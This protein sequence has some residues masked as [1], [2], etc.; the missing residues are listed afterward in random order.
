MQ[1]FIP[2]IIAISVVT[3]LVTII[4]SA[5]RR[6]NQFRQEMRRLGYTPQEQF[7]PQLQEKLT[8]LLKKHA[9]VIRFR[10]IYSYSRMNF[11]FY[12]FDVNR[13]N[14]NHI[15]YAMVAR[16]VHLPRFAVVPKIEL[17]GI[18]GKMWKKMLR[19]MAGGRHFTEVQ[20]PD[21]SPFT[22]KY[23]LFAAEAGSVQ[24]TVPHSAWGKLAAIPQSLVLDVLDD[25]IVFQELAVTGKRIQATDR[26]SI[27][28]LKAA[29]DLAGRIYDCLRDARPVPAGPVS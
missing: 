29:M 25:L 4:R 18:L 1:Q 7:D 6:Q 20:L 11:D 15:A 9:N 21:N 16:H 23:L 22:K 26:N 12:R 8:Q 10:N 13:G 3:L 28:Q 5:K 17:P 19:Y 27:P 14:E 2:V 24:E